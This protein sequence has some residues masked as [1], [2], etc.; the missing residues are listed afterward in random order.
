MPTTFI[1]SNFVFEFGK[2]WS[3]ISF[4]QHKYFKMLSGHGLSGVDFVAFSKEEVLLI[5]VKNYKRRP[6]SP[7]PPDISDLL[8]NPPPLAHAFQEKIQDS[9]QIFRVIEAYFQRKWWFSGYKKLVGIWKGFQFLHPDVYFWIQL[10]EQIC[11]QENSTTAILFLE[12]E[13]Q[14]PELNPDELHQMQLQLQREMELFA[15][16]LNIQSKILHLSTSSI[17]DLRI[18]EQ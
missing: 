2:T 16:K 14:Y 7:K 3:V 17:N 11:K 10:F 15:P 13:S 4:D 12:V 8:G 1:E 5:E 6:Q 9:L 18:V